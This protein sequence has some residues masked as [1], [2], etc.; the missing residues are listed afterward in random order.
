MACRCTCANCGTKIKEEEGN[1]IQVSDDVLAELRS[2][3][4]VKQL[5]SRGKHFVLCADCLEKILGRDFKESDFKYQ[6]GKYW[7]RSNV[8]YLCKKRFRE[9]FPVIKEHYQVLDKDTGISRE[10]MPR[11][12]LSLVVRCMVTKVKASKAQRS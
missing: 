11:L 7:K 1:L 3:D 5:A 9:S 6:G 4:E 12:S 2:K 10:E 8:L